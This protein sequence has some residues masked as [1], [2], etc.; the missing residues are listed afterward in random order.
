MDVSTPEQKAD[1]PAKKKRW[2][3]PIA[4]KMGVSISLL[5]VL[6]MV[7]LAWGMLAYQERANYQQAEE[8]GDVIAA[9]LA[10]SVTEPLFAG[11]QLELEVLLNNV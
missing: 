3:L 10:A 6:G 5:L 7:A 11:G 4:F 2:R 9:Q 1:T 8:F